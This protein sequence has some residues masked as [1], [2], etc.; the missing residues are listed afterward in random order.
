[1]TENLLIKKNY[2]SEILPLKFNNDNITAFQLNPPIDQEIGNR[3]SYHLS[4]QL[5]DVIIVYRKGIFYALSSINKFLPTPEVWRRALDQVCSEIEDFDHIYWN[6][7]WLEHITI[8]SQIQSDFAYQTLKICRPFKPVRV[9]NHQKYI[10]E[11]NAQFWS[12]VV[13][14]NPNQK[15]PAFSLSIKSNVIANSTLVQF[16]ESHNGN[17][18]PEKILIDLEV[19][20]LHGGDIGIIKSL[21]GKVADNAPGLL[22]KATNPKSREA[23]E[24]SIKN[25]PNHPLVAVQFKNNKRQY[26]YS[27][28]ALRPVITAKNSSQLGLDFGKIL[29]E[30]KINN[31]ERKNLLIEYKT[32][33]NN[34]LGK[35]GFTISKSINNE[36][37][38]NLFFTPKIPIEDVKLLF[39]N[40]VTKIHKDISKGLKEGGVY[41]YH[42]QFNN[43]VKPVIKISVLKM[44]EIKITSF[45]KS[46]ERYCNNYK[47]RLEFI[48]KELFVI[49]NLSPA[50]LNVKIEEKVNELIADS[51]DLVLVIL[52]DENLYDQ[53]YSQLLKSKIA[54]QFIKEKT[55]NTEA[56]YILG[57][58]V[59]GILAKLGNL[60]FVL[61]KPLTIADYIIGLD[62]S[63]FNK[64]KVSGSLNTCASIRVYGQ[65]GEFLGYHLESDFLEGEEIPST[66]LDKLLPQNLFTNKT[67]LIYR[68]GLFRGQE[69][70][71]LLARGEAINSQL[72]L[73]ECRKS[74]NPRL[75]ESQNNNISAP[76]LGLT[77]K[78][79]S[80]DAIVVTT[81]VRE[82]IGLA[83]P[84]RLKI[85]SEGK[86][87]AMEDVV[88]TTLK[89]TLLHHGALKTTRLPMPL[90]GADKM[91]YLRLRGV[92]PQGLG[93]DR[94]FWL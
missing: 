87:V 9:S 20:N 8:N 52:K 11:R 76:P 41:Q 21:A 36:S 33:A 84:L 14:I 83:R 27:M 53:I 49:E 23:L 46:L 31:L 18:E 40:N 3:V 85:R 44:A 56:N 22:A 59:P 4:R 26:H 91:A 64:K 75:Y 61:A 81:S 54:S 86:Q 5:Q 16:F 68:D 70:T 92:N 62:I 94:Q 38:P 17:N 15:I 89:L 7:H 93:G 82:N 25:Y 67:I 60:P 34:I 66:I 6:F 35:Y 73:V 43:Q 74:G 10:I 78:I 30:T 48:K 50:K 32:Q 19:Q 90:Y 45:L 63:R 1:M 57:Q 51:P 65:K 72:I 28:L 69:V 79:S 12:E 58:I 37:Q 80:R 77:L 13:E 29:K 24:K 42:S 47:F 55:L 39:G 71:Y 2:L 88:D